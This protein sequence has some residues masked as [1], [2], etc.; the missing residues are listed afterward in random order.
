MGIHPLPKRIL[1][2]DGLEARIGGFD[3]SLHPSWIGGR[4]GNAV[5]YRTPVAQ[6]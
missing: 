4:G 2:I 3:K 5:S 1:V 6:E